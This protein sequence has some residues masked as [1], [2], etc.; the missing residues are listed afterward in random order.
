MTICCISFDP[1]RSISEQIWPYHK[2]WTRSTQRHHLNQFG[3]TWVLD[4]LYQVSMSS[5]SLL[6]RKT[7]LK[8]FTIYG[9]GSHLGHVTL[10]IWTNFHPNIPWRLRRKFGFKRPKCFFEEK[11]FENVE[12]V[13]QWMALTLGCHVLIYLT[14]CTNFHLSSFNSF[15]EIYSLSIFPYKNKRDQFWPWCKIN[16]GNGQPRVIIWIYLAVLV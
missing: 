9:L 8:V 14:I 6:R 16:V 15:L 11:K 3:S 2:K 1:C 7:F 4:A 12:S 13:C 10:N 5:A